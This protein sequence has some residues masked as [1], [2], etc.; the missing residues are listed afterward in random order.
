ML[1]TF[2]AFVPYH[3]VLLLLLL[4]FDGLFPRKFYKAQKCD[5][6]KHY[7]LAYNGNLKTNTK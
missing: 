4:L 7:D 2:L 6:R 3:P 1:K 5:I